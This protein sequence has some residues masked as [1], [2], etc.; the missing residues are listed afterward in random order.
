[1][2]ILVRQQAVQRRIEIAD[3]SGE[4]RLP[5]LSQPIELALVRRDDVQFAAHL[6][7]VHGLFPAALSLETLSAAELYARR[8]A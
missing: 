7:E 1:M 8:L 3:V 4:I 5:E 6:F 2:A